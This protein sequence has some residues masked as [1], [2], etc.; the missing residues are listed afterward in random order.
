M[1]INYKCNRCKIYETNKFPNIKK[2]IIRKH[3]CKLCNESMFTSEDQI[4]C[5]SLIPYYNNIHNIDESEIIRLK[6][7]NI[8]YKNKNELFDILDKNEIKKTK[9]C[10][11]CNEEFPLIMDLKKHLIT[12]CFYNEIMSREQL[13]KKDVTV[14][15]INTEN[16]IS[17]TNCDINTLNNTTNNYNINNI[18]IEI[19]QPIPFDN[20]WDISEISEGDKSK[21]MISKYMYTLLLEE[22][23]KKDINLNVII[24]K[25]KD[26]G[27]VYKN[28]N[29]KYINMKLKD[30]IDTTMEKLNIILNDFNKTNNNAF[31]EI[32]KYTRR[33]INKKHCDYKNKNS[34][35]NGV[36]YCISDIYTNIK[37]DALKIAKNVSTLNNIKNIGY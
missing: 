15:N 24:D 17:N 20:D 29:D 13:N 23:L 12:V 22:I 27:M 14:N 37:D 32:I 5:L 4:L 26:F 34:I 9:V 8:L 7:S 16:F 21:I 1:S 6:N 3:C 35:Q 33:M 11:Y 30:I 28:D 25:D 18:N 2:H 19:K 36:K 10:K 31:D